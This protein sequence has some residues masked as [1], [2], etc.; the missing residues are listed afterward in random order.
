VT[1]LDVPYIPTPEHM[2]DAVLSA[3]RVSADDVVYDLGCG[4]GRIV[5][6]AAVRCGARGVGVD[7]SGERIAD[8]IENARRA[9]VADR[10]SFLCGDLFDVGLRDATVVTLYLLPSLNLRLRPRFWSEL[11]PGARIV[12]HGFDMGDWAPR[13]VVDVDGRVLYSWVVPDRLVE[14]PQ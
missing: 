6:A 11:R 12:S 14:G 8:A 10:V 7:I 3:G 1:I 13:E 5:I 9:G 4:D 2:L